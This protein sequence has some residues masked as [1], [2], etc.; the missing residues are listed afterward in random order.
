[1]LAGAKDVLLQVE[2]QH[3]LGGDNLQ[4]GAQLFQTRQAEKA[5]AEAVVSMEAAAES[6]AALLMKKCPMPSPSDH[7]LSTFLRLFYRSAV[8]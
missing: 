7:D 5:K 3:E 6:G 8:R 4:A 1:V 2:P